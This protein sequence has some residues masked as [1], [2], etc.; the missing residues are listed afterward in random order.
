MTEI[1]RRKGSNIYYASP[2]PKKTEDKQRKKFLLSAT[3]KQKWRLANMDFYEEIVKYNQTVTRL[4]DLGLNESTLNKLFDIK[5][6]NYSDELQKLFPNANL[7]YS[8]GKGG[9]AVTGPGVPIPT[10]DELANIIDAIFGTQI[11]ST[12][13]RFRDTMVTLADGINTRRTHLQQIDELDSFFLIRNNKLKIISQLIFKFHGDGYLYI[14]D[15]LSDDITI[16]TLTKYISSIFSVNPNAELSTTNFLTLILNTLTTSE[17]FNGWFTRN[18]INSELNTDRQVIE[19]IVDYL[20]TGSGSKTTKE[21]ILITRIIGN[22][23][24]EQKINIRV[25]PTKLPSEVEYKADSGGKEKDPN[26][27]VYEFI[28]QELDLIIVQLGG[29]KGDKLYALMEK[30]IFDTIASISHEQEA[31]G[32]GRSSTYTEKLWRAA[33]DVLKAFMEKFKQSIP[34]EDSLYED[35]KRYMSGGTIIKD[36]L[37]IVK[38]AM[39]GPPGWTKLVVKLV[40]KTIDQLKVKGTGAKKIS[41]TPGT[42]DEWREIEENEPSIT[43]PTVRPVDPTAFQPALS[44]TDWD[45]WDENENPRTV[46]LIERLLNENGIAYRNTNS[47]Y[48]FVYRLARLISTGKNKYNNNY[49]KYLKIFIKTTVREYDNIPGNNEVIETISK[50]I[51][52]LEEYR[53]ESTEYPTLVTPDYIIKKYSISEQTPIYS[54]DEQTPT[55]TE[56]PVT[57]PTVRPVAPPIVK[58]SNASI[59]SKSL[60]DGANITPDNTPNY[61]TLRTQIES[62]VTTNDGGYDSK[63]VMYLIS[64][65]MTLS[66]KYNNIQERNTE[67]DKFISML[68]LQRRVSNIFPTNIGT[69]QNTDIVGD[70][71]GEFRKLEQA[72][73]DQDQEQTLGREQTPIYSDDDEQRKIFQS[74]SDEDEPAKQGTVNINIDSIDPENPPINKKIQFDDEKPNRQRMKGDRINYDDMVLRESDLPVSENENNMSDDSLD[75]EVKTP[76]GTYWDKY[77][78]EGMSSGDDGDQDDWTVWNSDQSRYVEVSVDPIAVNPEVIQTV[79]ALT[80]FGQDNLPRGVAGSVERMREYFRGRPNLRRQFVDNYNEWRIRNRMPFNISIGFFWTLRDG[81][82]RGHFLYFRSSAE[83]IRMFNQERYHSINDPRSQTHVFDHIETVEQLIN[84]LVRNAGFRY[85]I[86]TYDATDRGH[87][88]LSRG[89]VIDSGLVLTNEYDNDQDEGKH[90]NPNQLV[91]KYG[92]TMD[93]EPP[94]DPWPVRVEDGEE[95][96]R[97]KGI[98]FIDMIKLLVTL[99]GASAAGV[100]IKMISD[101]IRKS[102][103]DDPPSLDPSKP[104]KDPSKPSPNKPPHGKDPVPGSGYE[105]STINHSGLLDSVGLGSVIDTYNSFVTSYNNL[106]L[107]PGD[108]KSMEDTIKLMWSKFANAVG[109][110][111]LKDLQEARRRYDSIRERFEEAR[112]QGLNTNSLMLLYNELNT[113][114]RFLDSMTQKYLDIENGIFGSVKGL[115]DSD[116]TIDDHAASVSLQ[117]DKLKTKMDSKAKSIKGTLLSKGMQERIKRKLARQ[118]DFSHELLNERERFF[119]RSIVEQHEYP[120]GIGLDNPLQYRNKEYEKIRYDK[121]APNPKPFNVPSINRCTSKSKQSQPVLYNVLM[122]DTKFDDAYHNPNDGKLYNP[123]QTSQNPTK[124]FQRS[125]LYNPEYYLEEAAKNRTAKKMHTG[126]DDIRSG[127]YRWVNENQYYQYGNIQEEYNR[128]LNAFPLTMEVPLKVNTSPPSKVNVKLSKRR[129]V[130]NSYSLK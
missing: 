21:F 32:T 24:K 65:L 23:L 48:V 3:N 4:I 61:E 101:E 62:L 26:T 67:L 104:G 33:A 66:G 83:A 117:T 98:P 127:P 63:Y 100:T 75:E 30:A 53:M 77:P 56:T 6:I 31:T 28:K 82:G 121:P 11:G 1:Y 72:G 86:A 107:S 96:I 46:A 18:N 36:F 19:K 120:I 102:K 45:N 71:E 76:H 74:S 99:A 111:E 43:P 118:G 34:R 88:S 114:A 8:G 89:D 41:T 94:D 49:V 70:L 15:I 37:P 20:L 109:A 130:P 13:Q 110:P 119:G 97:Y 47:Y 115:N 60:L 78:G 113:S 126:Y 108:R 51:D 103:K 90:D 12:A 29:T 80:V 87:M 52:E 122:T 129:V 106:N 125:R 17:E 2:E 85:N 105:Y 64:A 124:E 55:E 92:N 123:F 9:G 116:V 42:G 44:A 59:I 112:E 7:Q 91:D 5:Y 35:F 10:S 73:Q 57:P 50:L 128:K 58:V 38:A 84:G 22:W 79:N 81:L 93:P 40:Q 27:V 39:S 54:D 25:R 68:I 16:G 95:D 69:S 14:N